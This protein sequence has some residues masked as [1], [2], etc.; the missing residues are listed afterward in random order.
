MDFIGAAITIFL[1]I[2]IIIGL[3]ITGEHEKSM[4]YAR[5]GIDYFKEK[6]D[7]RIQTLL[8]INYRITR[9]L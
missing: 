1:A 7:K 3:Y 2:V 9:F 4:D 8:N 6:K 5:D